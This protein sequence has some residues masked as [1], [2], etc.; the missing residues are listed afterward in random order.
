MPQISRVWDWLKTVF[1]R[2]WRWLKA[3]FRTAVVEDRWTL[4]RFLIATLV[5]AGFS[6]LLFSLLL[7]QAGV[8]RS[9]TYKITILPTIA[10]S[11][12][13]NWRYTW[14]GQPALGKSLWRWLVV[15]LMVIPAGYQ[16][17]QLL[18]SLDIESHLA[19]IMAGGILFIPAYLIAYFWAFADRW[20]NSRSN[21][22]TIVH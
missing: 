13:L 2:A 18:A 15:Q 11:F 10:V 19:K 3:A 17:F 14:K 20:R 6:L 4:G 1:S 7:S 5:A 9:D 22:Q 16:L 21:R 8:S 12:V